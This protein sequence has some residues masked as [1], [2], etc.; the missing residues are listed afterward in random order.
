M[1]GVEPIRVE[2]LTVQY[3]GKTVLDHITLEI[4]RH[5]ITAIIGPA[6]SGKT[7]F[8]KTLNRTMDYERC[9]VYT[10]AIWVD[11]QNILSRHCDVIALRRKIGVVL[12]LPIPLPLSIYENVAYAPRRQGV[13]GGELDELVQQSLRRVMLWNEVK[14]RLKMPSSKLSGGQQQRLNL[15][16]ALS[17]NPEILCLDEFSLAMDP[18]LTMQVENFLSQEVAHMTILAITHI[19]P[20][21]RRLADFVVFLKQGRLVECGPTE[22]IFENPQYETTR[23]FL[24][25]DFSEETSLFT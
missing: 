6:K 15:A 2:D 5:R 18:V 23:K 16:H 3:A 19:I 10:G 21:V 14:D 20:Q 11:G 22:Q 1:G 9:P 7:S 13:R 12:P 25:G 24:N 4:P 8:L 17:L